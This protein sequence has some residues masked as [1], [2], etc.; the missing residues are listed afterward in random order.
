MNIETASI[1]KQIVRIGELDISFLV[2]VSTDDKFQSENRRESIGR[3]ID[4]KSDTRIERI[5]LSHTGM[6]KLFVKRFYDPIAPN[7]SSIF[8]TQKNVFRMIKGLRK[9]I[10]LFDRDDLFYIDEQKK[11][12]MYPNKHKVH[13]NHIGDNRHILIQPTIVEDI[14]GRTY[15]GVR[16]YINA[17]SQGIDLTY[18]E[19]CL[20]LYIIEKVDFFMYTQ[21]LLMYNEMRRLHID[22]TDKRISDI[23]DIGNRINR[24]ADKGIE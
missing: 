9:A 15:E 7:K 10:Q 20:L 21:A 2:L 5:Y 18:D 14:E 3:S 17:M 1:S 6:L 4:G 19:L 23:V 8:I 22:A 12:G 13:L 24:I 11:L 16:M